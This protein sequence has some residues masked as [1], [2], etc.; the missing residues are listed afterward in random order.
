MFLKLASLLLVSLSG[1][2]TSYPPVDPTYSTDF[3]VENHV[4]VSVNDK[5]AGEIR[6]YRDSGITSVAEHAFDGCTFASIMIS[7]VV[8]TFEATIP[9]EAYVNLTKSKSAYS[10]S[11]PEEIIVNEYACDE[12]FLNYWNEHIRDNIDGSICNVAKK[13]Y[14]FMKNLYTELNNHDRY[15]VDKTVDGTGTIKDSIKFLD[16]HFNS[17]PSQM[18]TKEISQSVMITVILVIASFGMTAIG[19]FYVLKDKKVIN[20]AKYYLQVW[21]CVLNQ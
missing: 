17:S 14:Y 9:D 13:H 10:Y 15:V 19:I 16:S 12:G 1:L 11:F 3:T 18:T 5:T 4:L 8:T 21:A 6:I 2:N 20:Q 7:D